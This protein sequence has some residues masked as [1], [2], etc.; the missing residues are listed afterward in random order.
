M[1]RYSIENRLTAASTG[2]VHNKTAEI[3]YLEVAHDDGDLG[4][5]DHQDHQDHEQEAEHEVQ[6]HGRNMMEAR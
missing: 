5:G 2:Y 4:A 1:T 3:P 6:L